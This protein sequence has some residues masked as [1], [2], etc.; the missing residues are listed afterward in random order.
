[1]KIIPF[2]ILLVLTFSLCGQNILQVHQL[3]TEYKTN[4]IGIDEKL[5]RLFWK[6]G[7]EDTLTGIMQQ[8][9]RIQVSSSEKFNNIIWDSDII[10]T[11]KSIHVAYSGPALLS[12]TR[13]F[14]RVKVWD[15]KGRESMWSESAFWEMAM[16]STNDWKAKWI[17]NGWAE[18]EK[19]L[20]PSS[21]F[22]KEFNLTNDVASARM[23][24]TSHGL[25][26]ASI[27]GQKIT[28]DL[29]TPGW[30]SYH[31]RLQYQ[32]YDITPF[33]RKGENAVGIT[34][35]DG[36]YRGQFGFA[37]NWNVYGDKLAL[38]CQIEITYKN[39]KR[40][41]VISDDSWKSNTGG[42]LYSSIYHGEGYDARK[43]P[44]GWENPSFNDENWQNA[45]IIDSFNYNH[46]VAPEGPPVRIM[47]TLEPV[48]IITT[49][50]GEK[51]ID[52]GQNMVGWVRFNVEGEKGDSVVLHHAEV[53]DKNGNFYTD[54]LR[55]AEQKIKYILNG[56]AKESYQPHFTFQG[57]RYVRVNH[58]PGSFTSAN[59]Q[60][61]VIYSEMENTGSF[62]CSD[63]LV[64]KLQQ[65]ILW[66]QKGNFL[67]VP[68][69]C[70]QRDERMGWTGDA[71]AFAPTACYNFNAAA[72]FTKWLQDIKAD[73]KSDGS[74]PFVVPDV[75][76]SGGAIG[77]ADVATILP[78]TMY[79]KYGDQR[80]LERQYPSMKKW[81]TF[82]ENLAGNNRLVQDG[83]HFGDWLFFIHPSD[84]NAK[85]GYT[86]ID[87][88]GT[89]FFAY[90]TKL[91]SKT[92]EVLGKSEDKKYYDQLFLEIKEAFQHEYVT[93]SG[94]LSPHSQTGYTLALTFDL[95]NTDQVKTAMK[96]LTENI[97]SRG[98][99]LSTGF[100]GTPHLTKTL[101]DH[102]KTH[103]AYRLLLQKS[104]PSWLYPVTKGATT[105]WERWD[106]IKPDGTFQNVRMNS[107]NHYAYGA[108]GH[109]M[110]SDVAGIQSSEVRPGYKQIIIAPKVDSMLTY[111][112]STHESLYGTIKSGWRLTDGQIELEVIIPP[113]ST[114]QILLPLHPEN[115]VVEVGSGK[116]FYKY[117]TRGSE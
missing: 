24:I 111:A 41:T 55:S 39:G 10:K 72:F 2:V 17:T 69:D 116:Y 42:I 79:Q 65:N 96:Y 104:Y 5:P 3:K 61:I 16:L 15:N 71:Q 91:V 102:D 92:A 1:M 76:G 70:P 7:A 45:T 74:V 47:D 50:L 87:F 28:R 25:Y 81:V 85:P 27:N 80:I 63:S 106:G 77:W 109:W 103:V 90:S 20:N 46:L 68:T 64:N 78:W 48:A 44:V 114:A 21:L 59:F 98:Y 34:L 12:M 110:Y 26:D 53:L 112:T 99:H 30:T 4:P 83:F 56:E 58:W 86:D 117:K 115:K 35:G 9:Y 95:L 38:L 89:A 60:G 33:I 18:A 88:L 40:T 66:G 105:I 108:V 36:W 11:D 97:V 84:W 73:Q 54:N 31:S 19:Q 13:Y 29:F 107:F 43:T 8:A 32:T 93:K 49:P 62:E 101:S 100:L 57:F 23:Y 82:L 67:D 52:F 94:R 6:I 113:N 75:L 37:N 51:I 22:R 14:W